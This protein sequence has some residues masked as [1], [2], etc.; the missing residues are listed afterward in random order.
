MKGTQQ[1]QVK[2]IKGV[3]SMWGHFKPGTVVSIPA[4]AAESWVR[5]GL[6]V[7]YKGPK[8]EAKAEAKPEAKA[9]AKLKTKVEPKAKAKA[10][11]EPTKRQLKEA[12][13][14]TEAGG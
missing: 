14:E 6:A 3:V 8:T 11:S 2:M 13:A 4:N 5:N 7:V 9:E 12:E 10:K 1:V